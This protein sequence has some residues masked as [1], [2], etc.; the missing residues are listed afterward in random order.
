MKPHV[1]HVFDVHGV[2]SR[3]LPPPVL[4]EGQQHHGAQR[5][6]PSDREGIVG[7]LR[8]PKS[9]FG[10]VP[11]DAQVFDQRDVGL[12]LFDPRRGSPWS[13]TSDTKSITETQAESTR[14]TAVART[15]R[16]GT[17]VNSWSSVMSP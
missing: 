6:T 12:A 15:Y 11:H 1:A 3:T 5:R 8:G 13:S 14:A 10:A 2:G 16:V 9:L 4:E 17:G 7:P